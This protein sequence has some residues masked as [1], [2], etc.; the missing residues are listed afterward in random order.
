MQRLQSN[1]HGHVQGVGFRFTCVQI[2]R[3]FPITGTV[4][5]LADGTVQLAVQGERADVNA[6]LAE[7]VQQFAGNIE[8]AIRQGA[9]VVPD[10]VGFQVLH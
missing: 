7:V 3:R 4:Q 5:N 8:R 2:A 6:Y 9:T 10:E 1:F